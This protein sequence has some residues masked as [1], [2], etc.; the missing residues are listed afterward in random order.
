MTQRE[1]DGTPAK[2]KVLFIIGKLATVLQIVISVVTLILLRQAELIPDRFLILFGVVLAVLIIVFWLLMKRKIKLIRFWIGFILALLVSVGMGFAD[3]K[4]YEL[5]HTLQNITDTTEET[6]RVG[7]YV[8]ADDPAQSIEDM[9]GYSYG[10]LETQ[11]REETDNVI[12]QI[13]RDLG[14]QIAAETFADAAGLA[15]GLL[16]GEC[17]AM[18]LNEG[19]IGMITE[20]DGYEDFESRI[21]EVAVYEWATVIAETPE[22][23]EETDPINEDGIFTMYISGIDT[24][25]S[26]SAKSRSDVNILA[27]VNTNTHQVLL[28]S[29]PR[30]YYVPLSISNGAKDKLT[31]AGIYGVNVS[32]D[33]LAMLYD[34]DIDYY[35]RVNF[36]GF[37]QLINAL[38]GVTVQSDY[39]FD[40]GGY[41]FEQ[42][43]NYVN[44]EQALAFARERYSFTE[45]DRQR[46]KNQ[47]AVITGVINKMI[48]PAVLNDFTGL[49]EGLEGSFESDIPYTDLAGLV[50]QQLSD[51]GSWNVVTYSADGTGSRASTYSMSSR[52]YVMIPDETTV[53]HAKELISQV[54]SGETLVQE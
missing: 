17:G 45:G 31:H 3:L 33:T 34:I 36:S 42:G 10:I 46:G 16:N 15:D 7:V 28:V 13:D 48:S 51:G 38:G 27:V 18:I 52:L 6:T 12:A 23:Q 47:M 41:H 39:S 20:T 9:A 19:F 21:R 35:F 22:N 8:L 24:F 4:I 29:T 43:A 11:A 37:E 5:T 44:G 30:D 25:G 26:I 50:R 32:M 40:A 53:D 1:K 49:M 2:E 54:E 14:T